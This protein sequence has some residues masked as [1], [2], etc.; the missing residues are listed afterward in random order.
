MNIKAVKWFA[1]LEMRLVQME[2]PVPGPLGAL[3]RVESV[4]VCGSDVHYFRDGRI[5]ENRLKEPTI[6][7]H[8]Y[9]GVVEAVGPEANP[10]LV[11][12]RVRGGGHD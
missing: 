4:G 10:G 9:A 1:P 12:R 2:K 11:G 3:V 5:G 7:G 6:L 8:E